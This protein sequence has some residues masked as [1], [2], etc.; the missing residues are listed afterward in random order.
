MSM[1]LNKYRILKDCFFSFSI[2]TNVREFWNELNA[3]KLL[4]ENIVENIYNN[5]KR[6]TSR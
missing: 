1:K 6:K 5:D 2:D 3:K 4:F